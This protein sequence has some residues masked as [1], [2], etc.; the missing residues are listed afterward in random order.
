ME[1]IFVLQFH[2]GDQSGGFL[3]LRDQRWWVSRFDV[4]VVINEIS[5]G[6]CFLWLL[7]VVFFF[8]LLVVL[9]LAI[10]CGCWL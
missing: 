6:G 7:L 1:P 4:V 10:S 3:D 2:G 8:S 9:V 5:S